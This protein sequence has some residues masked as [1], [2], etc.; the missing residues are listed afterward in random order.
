MSVVRVAESGRLKVRRSVAGFAGPRR[1]VPLPTTLSALPRIDV[2][3]LSHNHYDHLDRGTVHA[4]AAQPGGPPL[5][6]VPLGVDT[7][8]GDP[9]SGFGLQSA[10]YLRLGQT[11]AGL[12]LPTV[13]TFEG[14]YAVDAVGTN[15]VNLLE[16]FHR[17]V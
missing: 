2:V 13:F 17:T 3:L 10:D 15:A 11:L 9:I 1:R 8:A 14:G 12:G 6:V 16:G 7:F 4:L 5:F